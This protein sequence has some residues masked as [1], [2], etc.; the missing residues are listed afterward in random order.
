[1][2]HVVTMDDIYIDP[3]KV[4]VVVNWSRPTNVTEIRSFLGLAECYRRFLDGFSRLAALLARLTRKNVK[5]E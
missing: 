2:G 3:A 5:F 1:M 4:K